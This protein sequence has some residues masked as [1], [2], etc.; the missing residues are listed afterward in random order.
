VTV[1]IRV[2]RL[3]NSSVRY[4]VAVFR[5]D[6]DNPSAVAHFVHVYVDRA[7]MRPLPMPAHIRAGLERIAA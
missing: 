5:E 4:D 3:G 7:T 6:D 2:A 1:G